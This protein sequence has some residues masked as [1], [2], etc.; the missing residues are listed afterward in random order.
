MKKYILQSI[1]LLFI[2]LVSNAGFVYAQTAVQTSG[3]ETKWN[4]ITSDDKYGKFYAP[5]RVCIVSKQNNVPTRIE[6]WIKTA[7]TPGGAAETIPAMGLSKEITNPNSLKYSL[8]LIDINPQE[9][10]LEYSQEI[11]Y[12]NKGT[13]LA[14]H[15]YTAPKVKEINSQSFDENFY[16]AI[17][18][19]VFGQGETTRA[20]AT[21][22]W[23]PLWQKTNAGTVISAAADTTTI[24]KSGS[25]IIVWVWQETKNSSKA[26]TDIK[27]YKKAY[28]LS[29][30]SY[31]IISFS[32]WT[33]SSKWKSNNA[34]LA[35]KYSS[36]IP[37]SN[38]D[39]ELRMIKQYSDAHSAWV[40]RYQ[41]KA[42]AVSTA[43]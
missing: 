9:R 5:E 36:I 29:S 26:V 31:K 40:D 6:A 7:Y 43:K 21:D 14:S 33:P 2:L 20:K 41:S 32:E 11:F 16:D 24:R 30:Y 37:D 22:R 27:F 4:W 17:V 35:G 18:D 1:C 10:T 12:D 8:A 25:D 34:S 3:N 13:V 19:Q 15:K 23:A 39:T 28:N 38:E 42:A